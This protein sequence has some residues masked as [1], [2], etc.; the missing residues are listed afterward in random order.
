MPHYSIGRYGAVAQMSASHND[1][2]KGKTMLTIEELQ[3]PQSLRL[4]MGELDAT[5]LGIAQA[6]VRLAYGQ[7]TKTSRPTPHKLAL[8]NDPNSHANEQYVKG[9]NDCLDAILSAKEQ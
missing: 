4:A 3:N 8:G 1:R 5:E 9:W 7:L 2:P 6:A